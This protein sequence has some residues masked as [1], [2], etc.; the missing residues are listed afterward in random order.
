MYLW[1][2][3]PAQRLRR[4]RSTACRRA[5]PADGLP[6]RSLAERSDAVLIAYT[7]GIHG[8]FRSAS[9]RTTSFDARVA[10]TTRGE[11]MVALLDEID[12]PS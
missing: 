5:S 10:Q 7:R 2:G 9:A 1:Q 4:T 11:V 3:V 6:M 8:P 12:R